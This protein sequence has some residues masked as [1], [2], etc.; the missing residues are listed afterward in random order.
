MAKK[1]RQARIPTPAWERPRGTIGSRVLGR[2]FQFYGALAIGA[3]LLVAVGIVIFAFGSDE[4]E[5]RQRPG[6]TALQVEGT[7]FRLDYFASRLGMYVD[8]FGGQG[9][10]L[11]QPETALPA[12][13]D[14]LI[15]EEIIRR[16][17]SEFDATASE[18][19][20]NAEIA[21]RLGI[22]VD[23]ATFD[24]VF[25]Q[26]L[27]RSG[28]SEDDYRRMVEAA[29][30]GRKI[31]AAFQAEVPDS[32][33]SV[34][35]R[36]ILVSADATAQEL[37]EQIEG[38]ADFAVL[39]AENSLDVGTK[40]EG[41]EAGWIPRGVLDASTEELVFSLEVGEVITIPLPE[42]VLV[43]EMEEK[44]EDREIEEEQKPQLAAGAFLDWIQEKTQSLTIVNSMD[45][46]DGDPDKIRWAVD[47]AYES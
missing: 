21:T 37:R 31:R 20:M 45:L 13:T 25:Q 14:L 15:Q 46:S 30:L 44:A 26:E 29:V 23:D 6:S 19:E 39:A 47:R 17:A 36:Q 27:E 10:S 9:A 42:G 7:E 16:F 4:L 8:Q 5:K 35:Y 40:D 2:S 33:E 34:R 41:G 3:L 43:V 18:E 24:V 32:A 28:I 12:T 38:G 22:T 11:A 1:R